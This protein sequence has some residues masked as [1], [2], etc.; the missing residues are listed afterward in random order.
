MINHI[1]W[2]TIPDKISGQIEQIHT[3]SLPLS[4]S[5][6]VDEEIKE[7]QHIV[8]TETLILGDRGGFNKVYLHFGDLFLSGIVV[9]EKVLIINFP[10]LHNKHVQQHSRIHRTVVLTIYFYPRLTL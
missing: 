7:T 4:L 6:N 1:T 2:A 8:V 10:L 9:I 3:H 5:V